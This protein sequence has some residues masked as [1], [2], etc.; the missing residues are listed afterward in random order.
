[1]GIETITRSRLEDHPG[2]NLAEK[3]ISAGG[4]C[5]G[6]STLANRGYIRWPGL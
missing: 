3:S 4:S 5:V 2:Q 6:V 1:M